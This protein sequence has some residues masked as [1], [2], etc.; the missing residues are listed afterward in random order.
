MSNFTWIPIYKELSLK[1]IDYENRQ[2]DLLD[3]IKKITT[4]GIPM[5]P[6]QDKPSMNETSE[7][8]EIDP[9]T[10]YSSFNRGITNDNRKQILAELK[11]IF[12]LNSEV[13]A[14]FNGI[15]V[16][17][18]QKSW[19]FAYKYERGENDIK[20]L[21]QLFREAVISG[22]TENTFN[23]VLSIKGVRINI[24]IGLFWI[25]PDKYLSLDSVMKEYTGEDFDKLDYRK[26]YELMKFVKNKFNGNSFEEI[27]YDAWNRKQNKTNSQIEKILNSIIPDKQL[28]LKILK[29]FSESIIKAND[30]APAGWNVRLLSDRFYLNTGQ[31]WC[32]CIR[33]NEPSALVLDKPALDANTLE[34]I[35][36]YK[37]N[38]EVPSVPP[39][40]NNY[41]LDLDISDV[42]EIY[43]ITKQAHFRFIERAAKPHKGRENHDA[44]F[45]EYVGKTLGV[46]LP[47]PSYYKK[48]Q[49][50]DAMNNKEANSK[51]SLN[52]ILYGPPGTGKTYNVINKAVEIIDGQCSEVR[53]DVVKRYNELKDSG[54]IDFIT[55]H[56][57]F[58]YEEFIEGI[59]PDLSDSVADKLKYIMDDGVFKSICTRAKIRST[60]KTAVYDFDENSINFFKM[61]LGNSQD[62]GDDIARYCFYNNVIAM[63]YGRSIDFSNADTKADIDKL[64]SDEKDDRTYPTQAVDRFK[65]WMKI[66]DIVIISSGNHKV[67]AIGKV[68]GNY[69]FDNSRPIDFKHYRNVEWL[70]KDAIIPVDQI[71]NNKLFSQ[72]TIYEFYKKDLNMNNIKSLISTDE[73]AGEIK[74]FVLIIDEINRGNISKIFGELITL[75]EDDKRLGAENELTVTLPYSKEKFGVPSNLYII[76][77]MNTAD[78]SIALMDTALRRRFTFVEMM[79]EPELLNTV[80]D[81]EKEEEYKNIVKSNPSI[82][83]ESDLIIMRNGSAINIRLMLSKINERIEFLYDRDHTIGHA[84]FIKLKNNELNDEKKYK[85]LCSIF[86]TRIIPLL[87][88]YFYED[89]EKIQM[90]LGD[91][92]KQLNGG[93]KD[94]ASFEDNI[95]RTRF[96]QSR[97]FSE[98]AVLG[99]DHENYEDRVTYRINPELNGCSID[100]EAFIKIY[101]GN[102]K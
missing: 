61:S 64:Y 11:N 95:N 102:L 33:K 14:D 67:S 16:M 44:D 93:E 66:N 84:Y 87:Q 12:K 31:P 26:Y 86:S 29:C 89:W 75:I 65:N 77:T 30:S 25:M 36:Q 22:I 62:D 15:P 4:T 69:F 13:P 88:E 53:D 32:I 42:P 8:R 76:G 98:K 7:L 83:N 17:T 41:S 40:E 54:Q 63:G 20:L 6:M 28:H 24:T 49:I 56:Q 51:L 46:T 37:T 27:S 43:E 80:D 97:N 79:P 10:F 47:I 38:W 73:S 34:K 72:Q 99:F 92:Y 9:F 96:I 101:S 78:R 18:N 81:K 3:I 68:T 58:S 70:Y 23:S 82:Q 59:K 19:L 48:E 39:R 50:E 2:G 45:V 52:T 1:L 60:S 94:T 90:V 55:F 85:E 100:V 21:W 91:H 74:P 57:S 71:M 35:N 5:I